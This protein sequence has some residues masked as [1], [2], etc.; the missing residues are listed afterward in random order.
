MMR[1]PCPWCGERPESEFHC[2]GASH[3]VRPPMECSDEAWADYLFMRD[4]PV[5]RHAEKWRHT[6]GCGQWFNV[7]RHTETHEI[8]AV[9]RM[10]ESLPDVPQ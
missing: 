7:L 6:Y 2:G 4:N 1:I 9:Y 3:L 8:S 5:G 10:T